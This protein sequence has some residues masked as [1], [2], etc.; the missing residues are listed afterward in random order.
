MLCIYDLSPQVHR[1]FF[2]LTRRSSS[3]FRN[4][5]VLQKPRIGDRRDGNGGLTDPKKWALKC[6]ASHVPVLFRT[7][8]AV[9]E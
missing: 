2:H 4:F 7:S 3:Y 6:A 9:F 5:A 1:G 8:L